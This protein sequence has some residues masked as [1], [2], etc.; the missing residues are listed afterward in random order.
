MASTLS[1]FFL[2]TRVSLR[3]AIRSRQ[4]VVC[5]LLLAC[6]SLAVAAWSLRH[7]RSTQEFVE[8]IVLPVYISFLLPMFSLCYATASVAGDREDQ[9]L[10][11]LLATPLP[12]PVVFAAKF[13]ASLVLAVCWTLGAWAAVAMLAG[14]EGRTVFRPFCPAVFWSTVAYVSLFHLL[15]VVLRRATIV[16]F[17]YALFLETLLGN[18]PGIVKRVAIS[19]YTQCLILEAGTGLG[20]SPTAG[21]EPSLF[22]PVSGDVARIVLATASAVLVAVGVWVFSRTEYS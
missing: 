19:Y 3:R 15:S 22:M 7:E 16:G 10:V 20:L 13:T 14:A 8:Q 21:H 18:M 1:A 17:V 9:T 12:R 6:A 5:A 11:Y 2:L 4:T